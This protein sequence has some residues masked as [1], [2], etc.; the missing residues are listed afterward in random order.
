MPL[1]SGLAAAVPVFLLLC[2][3]DG[4]G[5][6]TGWRGFLLPR[7]LEHF[8]RL[9]ASCLLG[10]IWAI[11][12]LP[13][14]WTEG[15]TLAG[16]SPWVMIAELPAVSVIV[17]WIFEH[18]KQSALI[19]VLLHAAMNWSAFSAASGLSET[20][21]ATTLLLVSKWLIVAAI[22]LSW[23]R[24]ARRPAHVGPDEPQLEAELSNQ[25]FYAKG[26]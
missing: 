14:F 25:S 16:G 24:R 26:M 8:N 10:V 13:L 23:S 5:E 15:A 9:A 7:Q 4:L 20:W 3:T 18:T 19:A 21:Q 12:H 17:T 11:W 22:L 2:L 1:T 6:E